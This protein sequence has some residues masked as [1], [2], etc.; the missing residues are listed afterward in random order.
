VEEQLRAGQITPEQAAE[1]P[2]R[3]LITRAVG[4]Q[5]TVE[6]DIEGHHPQPNDL[7]LLASDGL[8]HE[9]DDEEIA[10]ILGTIHAPYTTAAL[11]RGCEELILAANRNGG[12]DNITVLL[13][14]LAGR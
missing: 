11:T 6:A 7:Y 12:H 3:N 5:A 10:S 4:S 1:S 13:V 9:V 2:M 14:S 8:T